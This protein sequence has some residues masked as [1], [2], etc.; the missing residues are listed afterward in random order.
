MSIAQRCCQ[1]QTEAVK[2]AF[3]NRAG[4]NLVGT[5]MGTG[6]NAAVEGSRRAGSLTGRKD[7]NKQPSR[8]SDGI[9]EL[10]TERSLRRFTFRTDD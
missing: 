3:A 6:R 1:P 9:M 8:E 7:F 10:M 2:R 5:H 4:H